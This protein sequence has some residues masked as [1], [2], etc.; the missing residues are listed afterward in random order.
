MP[1]IKILPVVL[2]LTLANIVFA[3]D[4][5][6]RSTPLVPT[7]VTAWFSNPDSPQ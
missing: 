6:F 3:H 2:I 4:P 7:F 1:I 5:N